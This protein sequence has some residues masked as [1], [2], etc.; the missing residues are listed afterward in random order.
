MNCFDMNADDLSMKLC[1]NFC[2]KPAETIEPRHTFNF[3]FKHLRFA[4]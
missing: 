3:N 4:N 1:T 2:K